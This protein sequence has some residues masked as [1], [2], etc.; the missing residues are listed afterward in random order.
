MSNYFL[1]VDKDLFNSGLNP[2]EILLVSQIAEFQNNT[3]D[4]FISDKVLAE[5]FGVSESTVKRA[6]KNLEDLGYITRDTRAVK[7]G[8]ERHMQL[9][10]EK[11]TS[12]KMS[13]DNANKA[14]NEPCTKLKMS[15]VKEQND[16][17]KDNT[18]KIKE[19]DNIGVDRIASASLSNSINS[20]EEP[21]GEITVEALM[22]M[23]ASYSIVGDDR[24]RITDTG[25]EFRLKGAYVS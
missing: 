1:K 3:G 11:L 7:G 13:F 2:L 24:V 9:N 8:R 10:T 6:I 15:F 17:I 14:Q 23:G 4:C 12:V 18:N 5:N 25:K 16:T 22:A 20:Q 19:K 21:V